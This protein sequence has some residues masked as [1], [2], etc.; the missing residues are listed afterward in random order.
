MNRRLRKKKHKGEYAI[1]GFHL[2]FT[3]KERLA[4][5]NDQGELGGP[6]VL[7]SDRIDDWA[8]KRGW[9]IAPGGDGKRWGVFVTPEHERERH[10][11]PGLTE[12]DREEI[13]AFIKSQPEVDKM[14]AGKLVDVWWGHN[15]KAWNEFTDEA[16]RVLGAIQQQKGESEHA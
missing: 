14:V 8:H 11:H 3:T 5:D 13:L 2:E 7:F 1:F 12:A 15:D 10:P 9:C 16:D 4:W 6:G